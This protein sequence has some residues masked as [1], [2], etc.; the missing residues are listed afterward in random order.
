M[1]TIPSMLP[2]ALYSR[3]DDFWTA[4][5]FVNACRI[6]GI[7]LDT[8]IPDVAVD[9]A[10]DAFRLGCSGHSTDEAWE[11]SRLAL[12]ERMAA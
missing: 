12:V 1:R 10:R 5:A 9:L 6:H 4:L 2:D 3:L 7:P 8:L 11:L